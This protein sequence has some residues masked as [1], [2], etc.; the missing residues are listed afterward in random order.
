MIESSVTNPDDEDEDADGPPATSGGERLPLKEFFELYQP[1]IRNYIAKKAPREALTDI[2][3]NIWLGVHRSYDQTVHK[4]WN[5]YIWGIVDNK[6]VDWLRARDSS[7][8]LLEAIKLKTVEEFAEQPDICD[9]DEYIRRHRALPEGLSKL[10][11]PQRTAI[12]L[13]FVKGLTWKDVANHMGIRVKSVQGH[14]DRALVKLRKHMS[15]VG[16]TTPAASP[17]TLKE[18]K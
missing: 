18:D 17:T 15:E 5:N 9:Q 6:I 8:K 7:R 12:D 1:K 16:L 13:R 14:V 10:T 4:N 2:E 11:E 3:S